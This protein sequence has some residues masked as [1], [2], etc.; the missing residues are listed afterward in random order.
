MTDRYF[1]E[2]PLPKKFTKE[3]LELI[4]V[5]KEVGRKVGH[6]FEI[7][8]DGDKPGAN[9]YPSDAT[10]GELEEASKND[11]L[12]LDPYTI[13]KRSGDGKLYAVH[14]HEEY[15]DL[16]TEISKLF[17]KASKLA[18]NDSFKKYLEVAAHEFLNGDYV[19]LER[20][21][22]AVE[23]ESFFHAM[24]GPDWSYSDRLFSIKRA[25]NFNFTC[26]NP[27]ESFNPS[28]YIEVI[29]N[30]LPPFGSRARQDI[31]P[32]NIKIRV[33]HVLC[34]GGRNA[35]LP[36]R[37]VNY[38]VSVDMM[39]EA[40]IKIVIYTDNIHKRDGGMLIP[41]LKDLID[42]DVQKGFSDDFLMA[43]AIKLVMVHEI[44]EAIFQYKGA[45][46]RLKGMFNPVMELHSSIVGIKG[47]G[48]QV[49]KEALSQK[50][51]EG[52]L[53]VML[54]RTFSDY[55]VRK[56]T[57]QV[58][59]YLSGY[60]VFY[61]YCLENG[62]IKLKG[63]EIL[64]NV[65]KMYMCADQLADVVMHFYAEGTEEEA[66]EFFAKYTSEYMYDYFA[67]TLAKYNF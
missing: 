11:H 23:N 65:S 41:L 25:Y 15:K 39:Q 55:F 42:N 31:P 8:V 36:A 13:V 51:L 45:W 59:N 22:L 1:L 52:I 64:P 2:Y 28:N 60:R 32:E 34:I 53:Y 29:R 61:N 5:L 49:I 58:E 27:D 46:E 24:A 30:V 40:G 44:T 17:I 26:S 33:D 57:P 63:Q 10:K 19:N 54:M 16:L 38:P 37:A 47:C 66:K 20:H 7:Q 35:A 67:D 50:D 43:S 4:D 6:I 18:K 9:F 62:A 56:K 48:F 21:W 14:Y 3:E 12:I